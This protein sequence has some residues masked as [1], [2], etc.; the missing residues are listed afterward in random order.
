M[1]SYCH[2]AP[3]ALIRKL[4]EFYFGLE[5]WLLL[6]FKKHLTKDYIWVHLVVKKL[7]KESEGGL[8]KNVSKSSRAEKARVGSFWHLPRPQLWQHTRF[9]GHSSSCREDTVAVSQEQEAM[10]RALILGS[11]PATFLCISSAANL[12]HTCFPGQGQERLASS[13][14]KLEARSD[15]WI[16]WWA[17][18]WLISE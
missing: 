2:L 6:Y 12:L 7:Q 9:G 14:G 3:E 18:P 11:S 5:L 16:A 10:H 8:E 1:Y 15:L 13:E 4:L 17:G